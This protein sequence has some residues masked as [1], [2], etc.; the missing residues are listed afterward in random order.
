MSELPQNI[1]VRKTHK[2]HGVSVDVNVVFPEGMSLQDIAKAAEQRV[3]GSAYAEITSKLQAEHG[4]TGL[5]ELKDDEERFEEVLREHGW[6]NDD[7][8]L[9]IN[10]SQP[11]QSV[12]NVEDL[13]QGLTPEQRDRLKELL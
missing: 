3:W 5:E 4:E 2:I 12:E 8:P 1:T 9:E 7:E 11:K 10:A 13:L 6:L